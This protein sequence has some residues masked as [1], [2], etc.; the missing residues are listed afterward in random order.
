MPKSFFIIDAPKDRSLLQIKYN[1]YSK[2]QK[3]WDIL[4]KDQ[5]DR[6]FSYKEELN[7]FL[8]CI[9]NDNLPLISAESAFDTLK[10]IDS[11]RK[12]ANQREVIFV[13]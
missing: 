8:E 1:P 3:Q 12:S 6:N 5:E 13:R 4:Y 10:T 2:N 11:I 7:H 9:T